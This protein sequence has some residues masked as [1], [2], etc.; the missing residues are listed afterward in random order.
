M[1]SVKERS[2]YA[3]RPELDSLRVHVEKDIDRVDKSLDRVISNFTDVTRSIDGLVYHLKNSEERN[4]STNTR[5]LEIINQV[6]DK[7]SVLS[8]DF[9]KM[10]IDK[11]KS[12][13][14]W[15]LIGWFIDLK[16]IGKA[17]PKVVFIVLFGSLIAAGTTDFWHW[18]K[19]AIKNSFGL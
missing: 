5:T 10:A 14:K 15:E 3:T 13:A 1:T 2:D 4:E 16:T 11:I 7:L 12:D 19:I 6:A 9:N 17:I 18:A 8:V